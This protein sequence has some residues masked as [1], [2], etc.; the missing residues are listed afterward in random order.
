MVGIVPSYNSLDQFSEC[1]LQTS[2][3]SKILS[4]IH[5]VKKFK[6]LFAFFIVL[7]FALMKIQM[8]CIK[9]STNQGNTPDCTNSHCIQSLKIK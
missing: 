1:G 7:T 2:E 3:V 8:K 4:G 6:M 9:L 5:R